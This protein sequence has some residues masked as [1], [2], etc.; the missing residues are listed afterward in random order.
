MKVEPTM[1]VA[2]L[3]AKYPNGF[4]VGPGTP[5]NPGVLSRIL[6]ATSH[7]SLLAQT[8]RG[9]TQGNQ[10]FL[11]VD[12]DPA[13]AMDP[14]TIPVQFSGRTKLMNQHEYDLWME[15]GKPMT[16]PLGEWEPLTKAL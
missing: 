7:F 6:Y 16:T 10:G 3:M 11:L 9:V 12:M 8:T 15:H 4:S 1:T 14:R 2:Q 13:N 5:D